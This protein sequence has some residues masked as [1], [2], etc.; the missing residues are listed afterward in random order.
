MTWDPLRHA[1]E[2]FD[3]RPRLTPAQLEAEVARDAA[4]LAALRER[5]R[6]A[7]GPASVE[8]A[9]SEDDP[10]LDLLGDL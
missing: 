3:R 6:L 2:A 8:T 9:P 10:L 5:D 1:A 4:W 7:L